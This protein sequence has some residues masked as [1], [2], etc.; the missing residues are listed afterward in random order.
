[1]RAAYERQQA[2]SKG[3]IQ[4]AVM[5]AESSSPAVYTTLNLGTKNLQGGS[6]TEEIVPM[7]LL[8][9]TTANTAQ[10]SIPVSVWLASSAYSDTMVNQVN[11]TVYASSSALRQD[12][13]MVAGEIGQIMAEVIVPRTVTTFG[14]ILPVSGS[15]SEGVNVLV[16]DIKDDFSSTG[17]YIAGFF[18]MAD[19]NPNGTN[20]M[21]CIHMDIYPSTPGG[22]LLS[23]LSN[24]GLRRQDFYHVLTHEMQHLVHYQYDPNE[25]TWVNEGFS[26]FAIYRTFA[27]QSFFSGARALVVLNPPT[28]VPS[29]VPHWLRSPGSSFLMNSTSGYSRGEPGIETIS[30]RSTARSDSV[31]L[32]GIGYLFFTY[33]WEQV[34]GNFQNDAGDQVFR[35]M[36]Q[37]SSTGV[38]SIQSGLDPLGKNFND[39][40]DNFVIA[41][42]L[43]GFSTLYEM[44][45]YTQSSTAT[46]NLDAYQANSSG[47]VT[48]ML[49]TIYMLSGYDFKHVKI[50]GN[51]TRSVVVKLTVTDDDEVTP[52]STNSFLMFDDGTG[53]MILDQSVSGTNQTIYV[54]AGKTSILALS[55]PSLYNKVV[56]VEY[57]YDLTSQSSATPKVV[58]TYTDGQ[59][60]PTSSGYLSI[61]PKVIYKET[62]TNN[63]SNELDLLNNNPDLISISAC[64]AG[65]N[66]VNA[67]YM[68]VKGNENT[69]VNASTVT[70]NGFS[71]YYS[72][73]K[74]TPN[75]AYD[76][77]FVN[78]SSTSVAFTPLLTTSA[79]VS[80]SQNQP[81]S[82]T[83][84][85][86]GSTATS[87]GGG[88]GC[89]VATASFG[90]LT[91][92]LVQLLCRFRDEVLLQSKLGSSF[93]D[94]YYHYS[95]PVAAVI[96][97][98]VLLRAMGILILLPFCL[99]V[100][101]FF[102]PVLALLTLLLV[103]YSFSQRRTLVTEKCD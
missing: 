2:A 20:R 66:C 75:T 8:Y 14:Q 96:A 100:W 69:G 55:N 64:P 65:N 88:G 6:E 97:D 47:D 87:S 85:G 9:K 17:S 31:E 44:D 33:L 45:F 18:D 28:D 53:K 49:P 92:P 103:V 3:K 99:L 91:N 83:N 11:S 16:Y 86:T 38:A 22:Y 10:G 73:L 94:I 35:N 78:K 82:S 27:N 81:P 60:Y 12:R 5:M 72:N 77:Y 98:H 76:L 79:V 7:T 63:T 70:V 80:A 13:E 61:A 1:L 71:Y 26:Q 4:S 101:L 58:T 41:L 39:I 67:S 57:V 52:A 93:V 21:N 95:P 51:S 25:T 62:F 74:L 48:Q 24:S 19:K 42:V 84:S 37:S 36:I 54:P 50:Q 56:K 32:R 102:H 46:L 43:D 59:S 90:S 89:F 40:F 15:R 68:V 30:G 34:G 29:Q 23:N